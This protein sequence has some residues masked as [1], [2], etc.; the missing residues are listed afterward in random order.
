MFRDRLLDPVVIV[1]L[2]QPQGDLMAK[3]QRF[4]NFQKGTIPGGTKNFDM[5]G[6]ARLVRL[7][8]IE[9][10]RMFN[11]PLEALAETGKIYGWSSFAG[12][13]RCHALDAHPGLI[14][15]LDLV[16]GQVP[17]IGAARR[18]DF[19]DAF[20][21]QPAYGFAHWRTADPQSFREF[22]FGK[23]LFRAEPSA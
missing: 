12:Q 23:W 10:V 18:A 7:C 21:R 11:H 22:P 15:L 14:D 1:N 13:K 20:A 3:A 8:R 19:D 9:I 4:T 16:Y 6:L 5:E 17:D 2:R